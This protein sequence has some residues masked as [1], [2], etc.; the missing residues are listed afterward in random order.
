MINDLRFEKMALNIRIQNSLILVLKSKSREDS[1]IDL[2]TNL[3]L[4]KLKT[5]DKIHHP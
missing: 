4:V 5:I 3:V 1:L 2:K